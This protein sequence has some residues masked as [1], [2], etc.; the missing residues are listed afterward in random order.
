MQKDFSLETILT[1]TTGISFT[2][3]FDDIYELSF[4]VY[5]DPYISPLGL[6]FI[7][8][9]LRN[10]LLTI[11][12]ELNGVVPSYASIKNYKALDSWINKQKSIFGDTLP[13]SKLGQPLSANKKKIK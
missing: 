13:V 7:K 4:F 8:Y 5:D 2:D 9:D 10:H 6:S 11:H 12:P 1:I 3:C